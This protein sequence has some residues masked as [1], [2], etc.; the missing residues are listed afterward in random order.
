MP[1]LELLALSTYPDGVTRALAERLGHSY[2]AI[3]DTELRTITVARRERL[4]RQLIA[5]CQAIAGLDPS[6]IKVEFTQH[7][8][9]EMYHPHMDGFNTEWR[10]EAG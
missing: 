9:D 2:A 5:D 7:A 10:A 6:R 3:M 4:A 8:G 1:S